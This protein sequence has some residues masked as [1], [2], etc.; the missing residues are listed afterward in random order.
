MP[1][2]RNNDATKRA[3]HRLNSNL[4]NMESDT[5]SHR[6]YRDLHGFKIIERQVCNYFGY[7]EN[8][9]KSVLDFRR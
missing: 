5:T 7:Q 8:D 6:L 2:P 4:N 9:A 1:S 3:T